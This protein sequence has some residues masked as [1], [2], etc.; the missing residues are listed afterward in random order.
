M[1]FDVDDFMLPE[2]ACVKGGDPFLAKVV[3]WDDYIGDCENNVAWMGWP[4]A[5]AEAE[6]A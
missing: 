3:E 2:W 6:I 1:D 4:E 5:R